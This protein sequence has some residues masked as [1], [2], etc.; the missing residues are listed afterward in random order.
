ME[1]KKLAI[2]LKL[3]LD[4]NTNKANNFIYRL[5]ID[6]MFGISIFNLIDINKSGTMTLQINA[7][8]V[9]VQEQGDRIN[10]QLFWLYRKYENASLEN[11][12]IFI[13][14]LF[15]TISNL[16]Y[17]VMGGNFK[18]KEK[19]DIDIVDVFKCFEQLTFV[20]MLYD[21]CCVCKEYTRVKTPCKHNLCVGCWDKIKYNCNCGCGESCGDCE[22]KKCP[23]CREKI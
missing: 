10:R 5:P 8:T 2:F 4:D 23:M 22:F 12:E 14:D 19:I 9:V 11:I 3:K 21:E 6:T 15:E 13:K 1:T 7:E 18:I 17:D 20:K 16:T